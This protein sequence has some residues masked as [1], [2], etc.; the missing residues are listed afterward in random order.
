MRILSELG[1]EV[2]EADNADD[3][4]RLLERG[5]HIDL[6]FTDLVMPGELD[7]FK[8]G[9]W[10]RSHRPRLKVLLTSGVSQRHTSDRAPGDDWPPFLKKPYSKQQLQ[11][12]VERLIYAQTA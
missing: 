7:G 10:A 8:L 6:L 12:A 2:I 5:T 4:A 11:D 9:L 1:Y 3:A